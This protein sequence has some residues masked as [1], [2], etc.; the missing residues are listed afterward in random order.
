MKRPD[1][2]DIEKLDINAWATSKWCTMCICDPEFKG[3]I[4]LLERDGLNGDIFNISMMRRSPCMN[5]L[6]S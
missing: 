2:I 1:A 3:M 5:S 6:T 4:M